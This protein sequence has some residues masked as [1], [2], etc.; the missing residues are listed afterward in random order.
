MH[1]CIMHKFKEYDS[2]DEKYAYAS[3][4]KTREEAEQAIRDEIESDID[5]D[6]YGSEDC[7]EEER[8]EV[9]RKCTEAAFA[10]GEEGGYHNAV[11][12][13]GDFTAYYD[14]TETIIE[15]N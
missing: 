12:H 5:A 1:I 4:H 13:Y 15:E 14:I 3:A 8:D 7:D 6:M 9:M 10:E 11:L 2:T